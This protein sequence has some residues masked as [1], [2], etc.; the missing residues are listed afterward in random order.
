MPYLDVENDRRVYYEFWSGGSDTTVVLVHGWGMNCR[1]WDT[2]LPCLIELG[3]NVL[4]MDQRCCGS[5]DKVFGDVSIGALA[6]DVVRLVSDLG[7]RRVI[8]NGWSLGGAIAIEAASELSSRIRGLMITCGTT[9]R[10]VKGA[11]WEYGTTLA[12]LDDR[13]LSLG[14]DRVNALY[15]LSRVLCYS[16]VG[17]PTLQWLWSIFMQTSPGAHASLHS[18]GTIDQRTKLSGFDFPV[19]FMAGK[20]DTRVPRDVA[21]EASKLPKNGSFVEFDESGHVPFLEQPDL[22]QK[23]LTQSVLEMTEV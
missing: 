11:D 22:Y 6:Q 5:S 16:D 19:L 8:L 3:V 20:H 21:Y 7:L 18:L 12:E 13:L 1:V 9:P 2:T 23:I 10:Y 17:E 4:T 15:E 14:R